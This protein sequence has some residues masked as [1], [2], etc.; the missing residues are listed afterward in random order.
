M[1]SRFGKER[2]TTV[3][4]LLKVGLAV[5]EILTAEAEAKP[6]VAEPDPNRESGAAEEKKTVKETSLEDKPCVTPSDL[7]EPSSETESRNCYQ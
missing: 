2:M 1:Y 3:K 7:T 5:E 4:E 6:P